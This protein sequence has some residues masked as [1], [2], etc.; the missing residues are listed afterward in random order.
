MAYTRCHLPPSRFHSGCG[1]RLH[2]DPLWKSTSAE[3]GWS[4]DVAQRRRVDGDV[5]G[6]EGVE[7][8][9]QRAHTGGE[10]R[11]QLADRADR[12]AGQA[13]GAGARRRRRPRRRRRRPP[14]PPRRSDRA[15][16]TQR[17]R[18][19]RHRARR[20]QR[21]ASTTP[22][23]GPSPGHVSA[24][25]C[26]PVAAVSRRPIAPTNTTGSQP[27]ASSTARDAL[28]HRPSVDLD[29]RLV[30][31]RIARLAPPH[32][33][34]PPVPA[35]TAVTPAGRRGRAGA[36]TARSARPRRSRRSPRPSPASPRRQRRNPTLVGSAQRT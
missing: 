6:A 36:G 25:T 21:S 29:E 9:V 20:N 7:R 22:P 33:T 27:A 8:L 12:P 2:Q 30:A 31:A 35:A 11:L 24:T 14:A 34:A 4:V 28:G 23:S 26:R 19:R 17:R 15:D 3:I 16:R 13:S 5:A 10:Q 32:S 1:A 18:R